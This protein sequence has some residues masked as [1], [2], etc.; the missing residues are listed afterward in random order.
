MMY[1][2]KQSKYLRT[3]IFSAHYNKGYHSGIQLF[4]RMLE[5]SF[6]FILLLF[7]SQHFTYHI[8]EPHLF[9]HLHMRLCMCHYFIYFI[10]SYFIFAEVD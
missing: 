2:L 3:V 4:A 6:Y 5:G 1:S 8:S 9:M 7:S 10:V